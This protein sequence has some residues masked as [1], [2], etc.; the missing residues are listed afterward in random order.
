MTLQ[1][2]A[3]LAKQLNPNER[4]E[5]IKIVRATLPKTVKKKGGRTRSILEFEGIS[6]AWEG[7][8]VDRYIN[9]MRDEWDAPRE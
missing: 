4:R 3:K 7:I 5:L 1:E 9:D 8:D 2:I 6:T